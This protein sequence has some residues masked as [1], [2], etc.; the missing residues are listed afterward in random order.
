VSR[1]RRSRSEPSMKGTLGNTAGVSAASPDDPVPGN[2][3]ST[4]QIPVVP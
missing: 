1:T 4:L 2:N 3:M